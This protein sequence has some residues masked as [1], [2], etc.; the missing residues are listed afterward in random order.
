MAPSDIPA[1][2][3][4]GEAVGYAVSPCLKRERFR[5]L[6]VGQDGGL[7]SISLRVVMWLP[8]LV[9]GAVIRLR[10]ICFDMGI[11]KVSRVSMPVICVGN[12]TTGG[13]GK[14]PL[15]IWLAGVLRQKGLVCSILTRGYKTRK[16]RLSDEPAI[17]TKSCPEAKVV[18]NPDRVAGAQKAIEEQGAQVLVMDDGF[19]HR[20][21]GRDLDI[22]AIDAT[23]PFGG[24]MMLPAGLL[25]EPASS[26]RRAGAVVITRSD[27]AMP[28][29]LHL[30]EE[31][32]RKANPAAVI[33]RAVHA[34]VQAKMLKGKDV[35]VADLKGLGVYA[36]C[37]IGNPEGFFRTL[38]AI[39]VEVLGKRA[40]DDHWDYS[41]DDV[42]EI[43]RQ[44]RAVD[45]RMI[46]TT[47]KDWV[48]TA[49]AA[50]REAGDGLPLAYLDIKLEFSE[51]E[52]RILE[53]IDRAVSRQVGK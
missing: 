17:L 4:N 3:P 44:A 19:Q 25:R 1:D 45:A 33:A 26:L 51:G 38:E 41:V 40:Y 11:I 49:L 28:V 15:V 20:R 9:Y 10:N 5:K 16:G 18:V 37:G 2:G 42:K 35:P 48:K 24:G 50:S 21:L 52:G 30:I 13:T 34:P 43:Y 53:L 23:C 47:Q 8:S 39:G 22:V 27:L 7:C 29:Q 32:I 31:R 6:M 14:T 46:L 12:I 36:F